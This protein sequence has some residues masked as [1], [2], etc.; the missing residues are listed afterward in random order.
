MS[1][2]LPHVFSPVTVGQF[3]LDHRLV[4]PTH[5]GGANNLVGSDAEFETLLGM[6]LPKATGGFRWIGGTPSHVRNPLPPGFEPSGV[7]AHGPG[8]FRH[9]RYAERIGQFTGRLKA[10]GATAVSVQMVQQGGKPIGPSS[11]FSSYDDHRIAHA[12]DTDEIA[13]L[14]REYGES[15]ALAIDAGVDV[16]EIHANH[17]DVVQW[18]LSPLT[19]LR[20]DRY[21][22][23][24]D[25]RLRYLREIT[26]SIRTLAPRPF[27]YGLRLCIDELIEGGYA[28]D[29][30]QRIVEAFTADGTVDYFSLDVGNNFGSPSYVPSGWHDDIEWAALCG[31]VKQATNLP[32]VYT[33]RVTSPE[34][35][36]EV[37]AAG[38][39]DLVAMARAT[40][41]DFDIVN[42]A[43][44]VNPE[45]IR[46]CI[47]LNECINR[48][49]V[50]GLGYACGVNP[51][52][53]HEYELRDAPA[54]T[55][56]P[57][58]VLVVGGG[59]AGMELAGLCAEQGHSVSLW[60]KG[61]ALGGLLAV[62]A[63]VRANAKYQ[64]WIDWQ[65]DRLARGGADVQLGREA[66]V[67]DVLAGG[68]DVVAVATGATPR[69]PEVPGI[70]QPHVVPA[71][72]V[73]KG[74]VTP[75]RRVAL[76]AE[77]DGPAPLSVADHLAALGHEVTLIVQTNGVAPLVGKYSIG[78][79]L[80]RLVDGGVR[81]VPIARA[82]AIDGPTIHLAS[83]YGTRWWSEG[84]FDN[85][86]VV[87]GA[88]PNDALWRSLKGRHPNVHVL[89]D[90]YAPRRVV[91]A[92]RQAH[93]LARTLL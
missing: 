58:R 76:L 20:T 83:T 70:D 84:P 2:A 28:L 52:W 17:D 11:T 47:G 73:L 42:K 79:M 71:G 93:E 86:V 43:R 9:P 7:G 77:D 31:Q 1:A 90:A 55:S 82:T 46:P 14:V 56:R 81:V 69:M 88:I 34:Q 91:F 24:F 40:F 87:A 29:E 12:L 80:A 39:A 41:A 26:E 33:G 68:F 53:A 51:Q 19:N 30:C 74:L 15:A 61:A 23:S 92:T 48:K 66:T 32:V 49:Q 13:W 3:T 85:V 59:P 25:N 45:P 22:G 63:L 78:T 37:L 44:G 35:A 38:H 27:T 57:Q 75:G 6:W 10:A 4:V 36:E 65:V 18:F 16:I 67:D 21:G 72:A 64:R 54:R 62:A 50:E 60:E 5:G 89:G 8:H